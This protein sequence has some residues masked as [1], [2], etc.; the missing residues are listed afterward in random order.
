MFTIIPKKYRRKINSQKNTKYAIDIM[1]VL[2]VVSFILFFVSIIYSL[3]FN[4]IEYGYSISNYNKWFSYYGSYIGRVLT[5][6]IAAFTFFIQMKYNHKKDNVANRIEKL[7]KFL[8]NINDL[9]VAKDE[10]FYEIYQCKAIMHEVLKNENIMQFEAY[11]YILDP[12]NVEYL[13]NIG[14]INSEKWGNIKGKIHQHLLK[15]IKKMHILMSKIEYFSYYRPIFTGNYSQEFYV[16]EDRRF[17]KIYD[18]MFTICNNEKYIK[19]YINSSLFLVNSIVIDDANKEHKIY[20]EEDYKKNKND[21][22]NLIK[23]YETELD[24]YIEGFK[25]YCVSL[26]QELNIEL[27]DEKKDDFR[28]RFDLEKGKYDYLADDTELN[29][30]RIDKVLYTKK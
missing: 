22:N 15:S 11:Y 14:E 17:E 9:K 10:F 5:V 30:T 23:I 13:E 2:L 27:M 25:F 28:K 4:Y 8:E 19:E 16:L 18:N 6:S 29:S 20:S 1:K 7:E 26:M 21:I 24:K 3:I 12:S